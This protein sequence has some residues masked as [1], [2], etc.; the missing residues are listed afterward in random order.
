M[1]SQAPAMMVEWPLGRAGKKELLVLS[2][3][4]ADG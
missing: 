4:L 1:I 2:P 3:R